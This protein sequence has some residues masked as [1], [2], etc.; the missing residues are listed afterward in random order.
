MWIQHPALLCSFKNPLSF[1]ATSVNIFN[2]KKLIRQINIVHF[3]I[4]LYC[5][6]SYSQFS[7]CLG[8]LISEQ[9][10]FKLIHIYENYTQLYITKYYFA[11]Y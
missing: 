1:L 3:Q 4:I 9:N 7:A 8:S 5:T 2:E 10:H 6:V 11:S